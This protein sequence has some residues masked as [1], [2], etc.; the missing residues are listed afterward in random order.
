MKS[1]PIDKKPAPTADAIRAARLACGPDETQA[2]AASRVYLGWRTWQD[3]E[4][5][6]RHMLPAVFELYLLKT[7]ALRA[8]MEKLQA[9]AE[10]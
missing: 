1:K 3:Y 5:G 9:A 10:A 6:K 4:L 7:K 2:K 8:R